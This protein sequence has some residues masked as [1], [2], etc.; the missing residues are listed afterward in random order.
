MIIGN[1][2]KGARYSIY[3]VSF[4]IYRCCVDQTVK[5]LPYKPENSDPKNANPEN[6]HSENSDPSKLK[7]KLNPSQFLS[8]EIHDVSVFKRKAYCTFFCHG[9]HSTVSMVAVYQLKIKYDQGTYGVFFKTHLTQQKMHL[10]WPV[11]LKKYPKF[12]LII[13]IF[14]FSW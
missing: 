2:Q 10:L 9:T 14:I 3:T 1:S 7:K 13:L 12:V 11:H 6:L 8:P 4:P 5:N